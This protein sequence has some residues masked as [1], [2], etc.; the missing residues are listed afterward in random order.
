[1]RATLPIVFVLLFAACA[2]APDDAP[3]PLKRV[4]VFEVGKTSEGQLRRI[5]G[6]VVAA[7]TSRLSFGVGGTLARI[8]VGPGDRF[9]AGQV[10]A[11]LDAEPLRIAAEQSRAQLTSARAKYREAE[12][13]LERM[14]ELLT[15]G[16]ASRADVDAAV[17]DFESAQGNVRAEEA[18][19]ERKER[20]LSLVN[21][22]APFDGQVTERGAEAFEEVSASQAVLTV[23]SEGALEV[24]VGIPETL[25]R[26]IDYGQAVTV[27]FPSGTESVRAVVTEIGA[28]PETGAA[29]PVAVRLAGTSDDL[30]PGMTASV[31]FNIGLADHEGPVY[32]IP[33]SAVALDAAP[34]EPAE[35][36]EGPVYIVV[37]GKLITRT[38]RF[39]DVRDNELE[40][41]SGLAAGDLVVSAGV[42]FLYDGMEVVIWNGELVDG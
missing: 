26:F 14:R 34:P 31:V 40:V 27:S 36:A 41:Y 22:M 13:G 19:V 6:R 28:R 30:R 38:V 11:S 18:N 7:D 37:D 39:G 20:D 15:R 23:Q 5:S 8:N 33:L 25:I 12:Q 24:E 9:E 10:L 42:P 4:K 1:M 29:Y 2:P 17:A 3:P 16:V 35:S 32:L 21:L